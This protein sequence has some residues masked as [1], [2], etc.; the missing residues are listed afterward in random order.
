MPTLADAEMERR[1]L[2]LAKYKNTFIETLGTEK[3]TQA[4]LF[5]RSQRDHAFSWPHFLKLH[6]A[7]NMNCT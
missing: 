1:K 4:N 7:T 2:Q 5:Q 3:Q 6:L